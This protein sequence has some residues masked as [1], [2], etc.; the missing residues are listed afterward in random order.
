MVAL[1]CDLHVVHGWQ[2][3]AMFFRLL[4]KE[5]RTC[6]LILNKH[7]ILILKIHNSSLTSNN[8]SVLGKTFCF[9][10]FITFRMYF[11]LQP[12]IVNASHISY[13]VCK[14]QFCICKQSFHHGIILHNF[15]TSY[16]VKFQCMPTIVVYTLVFKI[17]LVAF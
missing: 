6:D 15:M 2:W 17:H 5:Q 14:V 16:H 10:Y 4:A 7:V 11:S 3:F 1:T 13:H 8:R 12:S 9:W